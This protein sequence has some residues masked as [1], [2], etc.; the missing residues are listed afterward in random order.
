MNISSGIKV[1]K[2]ENEVKQ[3]NKFS[4]QFWDEAEILKLNARDLRLV[5]ESKGLEI[6]GKKSLLRKR[7]ISFIQNERKEVLEGLILQESKERAEILLEEQGCVYAF[8]NNLDGQL[9]LQNKN[10][11]KI[12]RPVAIPFFRGKHVIRV[13]SFNEFSIAL[14]KS[15]EVF[16]WPQRFKTTQAK[17]SRW[18]TRQKAARISPNETLKQ[19]ARELGVFI[20]ESDS[21][22]GVSSEEDEVPGFQRDRRIKMVKEMQGEESINVKTGNNFFSAVTKDGDLH[23]WGDLPIHVEGKAWKLRPRKKSID[24]FRVPQFKN[25][26]TKVI[27][28]AAGA[29]QLLILAEC[30]QVNDECFRQKLFT[31][32]TEI[33]LDFLEK[34]LPFKNKL[35]IR[36]ISCGMSHA[37]FCTTYNQ[38]YTWGEGD[39]GKLGHGDTKGRNFP[40]LVESIKGNVLDFALG[41]NHSNII[42]QPSV[43]FTGGA[44]FSF[45]SNYFGQLAVKLP[46]TSYSA[47]PVRSTIM[48]DLR[49]YPV[50]IKSGANHVLALTS[51]GRLFSWGSDEFGELGRARKFNPQWKDSAEA[52]ANHTFIPEVVPEFG[53]YV[54]GQRV[55]RVGRGPIIDFCAGDGF[56]LIV[57]GPYEGPTEEEWQEYLLEQ[58]E[59]KVDEGKEEDENYLVEDAEIYFIQFES[60]YR[61]T[62]SFGAIPANSVALI[63]TSSALYRTSSL[64][65]NS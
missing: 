26:T 25:T 12:Q 45:G 53:K 48:G 61:S 7:L 50:K 49:I 22:D 4:V 18:K 42:V 28:S 43:F 59:K 63:F 16:S 47:F 24:G 2:T 20:P 62:P 8:G 65:L 41:K 5:L 54:Y 34:K 37:A 58:E 46:G 51:N 64:L 23:F 33:K 14:T 29:D 55:E 30:K 35:K 31:W 9:G 56:S 39:C 11:E 32:S 27:S 15:H 60:F 36:K 21:S 57:T 6:K 44:I 38:I 3:E 10:S 17:K 1:E 13:S 40:C 19:K 52:G